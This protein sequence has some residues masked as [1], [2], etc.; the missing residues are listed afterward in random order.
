MTEASSLPLRC[1]FFSFSLSFCNSWLGSGSR[2]FE[3]VS[4]AYEARLWLHMQ[5]SICLETAIKWV[6]A[7]RKTEK[8]KK[9]QQYLLYPRIVSCWI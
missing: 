3:W 7:Q 9:G 2:C 6:S 5:V 4:P 8:Q 1:I